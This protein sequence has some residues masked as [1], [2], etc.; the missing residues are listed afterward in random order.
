MSNTKYPLLFTY[1]DVLSG[2]GFV[3]YVEMKGRSLME[4]VSE[5]EVWIY[6]INPGGIAASGK[7]QKEAANAFLESYRAVL[8]DIADEAK[9]FAELEAEVGSF[10]SDTNRPNSKAWWNA[11]RRVRAGKVDLDWLERQQAESKRGVNVL[12][13][14]PCVDAEPQ[15]RKPE[16]S[17][18]NFAKDLLAA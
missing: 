7:S 4:Q 8:F 2:N 12:D 6:G 1:H 9:G 5:D 10:Y 18:N 16:P 13:I 17:F 3:A 15:R 11:V 14:T